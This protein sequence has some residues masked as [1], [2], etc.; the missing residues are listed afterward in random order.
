MIL[1]PFGPGV[2]ALEEAEFQRA[3]ERGKTLVPGAAAPSDP[4]DE[5]RAL[6]AEQ[7]E[8]RTGVP[9][10]W[11]LE[12]ARRGEVPHLRIGRYPRFLWR[13]IVQKF[14]ERGA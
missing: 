5:Q 7:A 2:L 13:D 12:A 8:E 1:V 9:A 4:G 11:W 3:L 6:T 10:S 14:K